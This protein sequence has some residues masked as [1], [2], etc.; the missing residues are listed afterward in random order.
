MLVPL[1]SVAHELDARTDSQQRAQDE[2]IR[3]SGPL[4]REEEPSILRRFLCFAVKGSS[5]ECAD[6]FCSSIR[7]QKAF[8]ADG[9]GKRKSTQ[10]EN[11]TQKQIFLD[12]CEESPVRDMLERKPPTGG[13]KS[14]SR[15]G[16][17]GGSPCLSA[18][19]LPLVLKLPVGS[20]MDK[21]LPPCA[22]CEESDRGGTSAAIPF[23]LR[24]KPAEAFALL[25]RRRAEY[26]CFLPFLFQQQIHSNRPHKLCFLQHWEDEEL[27]QREQQQQVEAL[28]GL[29][30]LQ[31]NSQPNTGNTVR[32]QR[33][34]DKLREHLHKMNH[35]LLQLREKRLLQRLLSKQEL[36]LHP[37][38]RPHQSMLLL[39]N[40]T[41]CGKRRE[42]LSQVAQ[43]GLLVALM[44]GTGTLLF[45]SVSRRDH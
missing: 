11:S 2:Q 35:Q 14:S 42:L 23:A 22:G 4:R 17:E 12:G 39:D 9:D 13:P 34:L 7:E 41:E 26:K 45:N 18:V 6:A 32:M 16:F 36:S 27:Q 38:L 10:C 30:L 28:V 3:Y 21:E 37:L 19:Q 40:V 1:R 25:L 31:T 44:M 43:I 29:R 8:E 15:K 5:E 24:R 33:H 20:G